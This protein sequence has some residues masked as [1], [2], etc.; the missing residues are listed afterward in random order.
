M[1]AAAHN[2]GSRLVSVDADRLMP[3]AAARAD[4]NSHKDEADRLRAQVEKL[5]RDLSR[6]RRCIAELRRSKDARMSEARAEMN[7]S[8]LAISILCRRVFPGV[9]GGDE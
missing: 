6:A 1:G 7:A 9:R 3:A 4:R 8:R 2:R 5:E